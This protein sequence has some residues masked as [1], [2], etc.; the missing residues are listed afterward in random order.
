MRY[1]LDLAYDGTA[2]NG[3]QTQPGATRTV[4]QVVEAA[5]T[6]LMR[7][8]IA[9]TGSGRTGSV[10]YTPSK[11]PNLSTATSTTV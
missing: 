3:W 8:P 6:L 9:L 11:F 4:Q 2:F 5:L 10:K 1:R 7:E